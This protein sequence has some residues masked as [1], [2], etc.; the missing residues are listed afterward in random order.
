MSIRPGVL[1]AAALLASTA[2]LASTEALSTAVTGSASPVSTAVGYGVGNNR[3]FELI[4]VVPVVSTVTGNPASMAA[5]VTVNVAPFNLCGSGSVTCN[6]DVWA[7][8]WTIVSAPTGIQAVNAYQGS[9]TI[10][11]INNSG[12]GSSVSLRCQVGNMTGARIFVTRMIP[13]ADPLF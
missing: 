9:G 4:G 1:A 2:S 8:Q 13:L 5:S 12:A 10:R 7:A 11:L 3:V 6:N